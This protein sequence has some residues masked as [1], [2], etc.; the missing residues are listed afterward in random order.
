MNWRLSKQ[1]PSLERFK[2]DY[3][4]S[5]SKDD[6]VAYFKAKITQRYRKG[7][8]SEI[9]KKNHFST[10]NALAAFR[11]YIPFNSLTTEFADDFDAYLK[12][13]VPGINTRWGRHKDVKTY[14]ALARKDRLKFEDPYAD[15]VNREAPGQW[16]ALRPAELKKLEE[17][18]LLCAPRTA[19]RRVLARFLFSCFSSLRLGDLKNVANAAIENREMTF[20]AQKTYNKTMA[21]TMLPLTKKA[22]RFLEQAQNEEGLPGFYNY[23]DQYNNRTLTAIGQLLGIEA[24]IHNHVGRETF[25]TEFIRKGGNVAVLQKLMGHTKLSTTMK[26]VHVDEDMK[27]KEIDRMD[28]LDDA[29]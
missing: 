28:A 5:G 25:A 11:A 19:H 27:R 6:F 26:Y 10:Y 29:E 14:L 8:I 7:K 22:L 24:R 13:H 9:T 17:Y 21:E 23:A 20:K 18:Y 3:S 4:T 15:F 2:Q 1:A 12:R 16:K